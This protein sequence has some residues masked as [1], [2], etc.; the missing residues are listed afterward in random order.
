MAGCHTP[1]TP[2]PSHRQQILK[3][4]NDFIDIVHILGHL[5]M[6]FFCQ[7]T[8]EIFLSARLSLPDA[9]DHVINAVSIFFFCERV[10]ASLVKGL[11]DRDWTVFH[12][13]DK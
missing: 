7:L 12:T 10:W 13:S 8:Y 9:E 11:L 2:P 4:L 5:L 1:Y 3:N 6:R